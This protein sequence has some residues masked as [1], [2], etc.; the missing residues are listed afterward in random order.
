MNVAHRLG[1]T[2]AVSAA[3]LGCDPAIHVNAHVRGADECGPPRDASDGGRPVEGA[4]V[5]RRCGSVEA[6]LGRTG[7]DGR[8]AYAAL[9]SLSDDCVLTVSKPG[10]LA[11]TYRVGEVCATGLLVGHC[12]FVTSSRD[13]DVNVRG[14]RCA[15][16]DVYLL[17]STTFTAAATYSL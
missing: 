7:A 16:S 12:P 15:G 5:T 9:G 10:Y 6:M 11:R 17:A 14:G 13:D 4:V 1:W 3:V 2:I 8:L